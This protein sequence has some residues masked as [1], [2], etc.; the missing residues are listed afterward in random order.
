MDLLLGADS[1]LENVTGGA[2]LV[3]ADLH[4]LRG[5]GV[6]ILDVVHRP[7]LLL[8][9]QAAVGVG[10]LLTVLLLHRSAVLHYDGVT[11]VLALRLIETIL[12]VLIRSLQRANLLCIL[13]RKRETGAQQQEEIKSLPMR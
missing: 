12:A 13:M 7:A 8:G 9:D 3:P 2:H 11:H 5:A 10:D 1:L 4:I 6:S